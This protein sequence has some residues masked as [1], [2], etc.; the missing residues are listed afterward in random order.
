MIPSQVYEKSLRSFLEPILS[1]L[2]DPSVSEVMINGP[3][4]IYVE[5]RGQLSRVDARFP[6][7]E[8]LLSALSGLVLRLGWFDRPA[9]DVARCPNDERGDSIS[10]RAAGRERSVRDREGCRGSFSAEE[11]AVLRRVIERVGAV[12]M[13]TTPALS[14]LTR[15]A[16]IWVVAAE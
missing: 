11:L 9:H 6:S 5:R 1:Y 12:N 15:D 3:D 16:E 14:P 10:V 2:D 7:Q 4:V 8:A 13:W